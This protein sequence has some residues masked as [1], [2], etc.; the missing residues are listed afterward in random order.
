MNSKEILHFIMTNI[1]LNAPKPYD[2]TF[3]LALPQELF[4]E[5]YEFFQAVKEEDGLY[6]MA[7]NK[8]RID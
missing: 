7:Q 2:N 3:E 4:A 6:H 1:I 5:L 8:W